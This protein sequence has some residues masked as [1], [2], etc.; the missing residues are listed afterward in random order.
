MV[1]INSYF[2]SL[3]SGFILIVINVLIN[4]S[5]T[6]FIIKHIGVSDYGF[7]IVAIGLIQF[8]SIFNFGFG[9][10]F[11][12]MVSRNTRNKHLLSQYKNI[13]L[14]INIAIGLMDFY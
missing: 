4:I 1:R 10:A 8:L 7:Y 2:R 5:L 3:E 14:I 12:V 9:A 13:I 6:P 11:E